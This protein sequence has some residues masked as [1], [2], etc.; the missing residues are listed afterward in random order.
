MK[1][2]LLL[3]AS[4]VFTVADPLNVLLIVSDDLNRRVSPLGDTQ[5]ITPNLERLA[6]RSVTFNNASCSYALCGPSRASFLTGLSP[7][8][9]GVHQAG[10]NHA[11]PF[12]VVPNRP[13][14]SDHFGSYGYWTGSYGKVEHNATPSKWSELI[15][16]AHGVIGNVVSHIDFPDYKGLSGVTTFTTFDGPPDEFMDGLTASQ[17]ITAMTNATANGQPFFIGCGFYQPHAPYEVPQSIADLY[18]ASSIILPLDPA[19]SYNNAHWPSQAFPK[20]KGAD[21]RPTMPTAERQELLKGYYSAVTLMDSQLGRVL[22]H[23]DTQ[24]LWDSTIVVFC[25]DNGYSLM[26]HRHLFS[27]RNYSRESVSVPL[28]IHLPGC[29]EGEVCD[30]AVS[31]LDLFP[32][33]AEATGNPYPHPFDGQSLLPLINDPDSI[34]EEAAL[35]VITRGNESFVRFK[36]AQIGGW[37]LVEGSSIGAGR[38]MDHSTDPFEHFPN[39]LSLSAIPSA[40]LSF[41]QSSLDEISDSNGVFFLSAPVD[42]DRDGDGLSD[43]TEINLEPFGL[44]PLEPDSG[45]GLLVETKTVVTVG[46]PSEEISEFHDYPLTLQKSYDSVIWFDVSISPEIGPNNQFR[47]SEPF[48][49][50]AFYRLQCQ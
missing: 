14:M 3:L 18:D 26:E 8:N 1:S 30:E 20:G 45:L 42:P 10:G 48:E 44:D 33:L 24:N 41:L 49:E 21:K 5:A 17:T 28:F 32:T 23:L 6:E 50:G 22:D 29:S 38:V 47:W 43:E 35:S 39:Y 7:W 37:K 46:V 40:T 27:K 11:T 31:L 4:S 36:I 2:L 19:G 16:R 25:S 15:P 34:R 13:W 12:N 9:L